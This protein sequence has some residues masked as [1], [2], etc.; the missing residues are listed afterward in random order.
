VVAGWSA[1][2]LIAM[3]E[4]APRSKHIEMQQAATAKRAFATMSTRIAAALANRTLADRLDRLSDQPAPRPAT[5]RL[6]AGSLLRLK[7]ARGLVPSPCCVRTPQR[8][9][10]RS[11]ARLTNRANEG[12]CSTL[13]MRKLPAGARCAECFRGRGARFDLPA[14]PA[15]TPRRTGA[16]PN[17]P[18]HTA[19][20][21]ALAHKGARAPQFIP[22]IP[23]QNDWRA[24]MS[25]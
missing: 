23:C 8:R 15:K 6:I 12:C 5:Q 20:D 9:L 19:R 10:A 21:A 3:D 2:A 18:P 7:R 17:K 14:L 16:P 13:P 4:E 24:R 25:R 22:Q 1:S 11:G